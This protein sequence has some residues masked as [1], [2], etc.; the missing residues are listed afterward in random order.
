MASAESIFDSVYRQ[1]LLE[2]VDDGVFQRA[3]STLGAADDDLIDLKLG[4][5]LD[6]ELWIAAI[7]VG[8]AVGASSGSPNAA[9]ATAYKVFDQWL[10][11]IVAASTKRRIELRD[12][13]LASTAALWSR[14]P[15]ELRH[16]LRLGS[17]ATVVEASTDTEKSWPLKVQDAVSRALIMIARQSGREDIFRARELVEE[18]RRLQSGMEAG[19]LGATNQPQRSALTL[20]AL[21]HAGQATIVLTDYVLSG[22][23]IGAKGRAVNVITELQTLVRKAHEYAVLSSDPELMTWI[24]SVALIAGKLRSDSIWATGANINE[25]TDALVRAV[26]S[27]EGAILSM[28]PSQQDALAKNLLDPQREAIVLQ[29]PT[30]SGK[31][32]MAEMAILQTLS[33]YGDSR[34]V[35]LTPT[36]ALATQIRRTLGFDFS[37]LNIDVTSAGS[38]FEEDPFEQALL[39]QLSGVI[40]STP[41][42]L[43]LLLR[44]RS[45]W[46]DNVRLVIVDEAHLLKDG[47]RGA[48]LELLLSNIRREHAHIRLLLLTP[49]VENAQDV[50]NWL[51]ED[52]GGEVGVQWRPSRLIIG[53]ATVKGR[54]GTRRIE[55]EWKEPHRHSALTNTVIQLS[56]EERDRLRDSPSAMTKA[57]TIGR[58]L[59]PLGPALMMFPD[60]RIR[61]EQT[62]LEMSADRENIDPAGEGPEFRVAV[63]LATNEYGDNSE[64][65]RCLKKGVAFHHSALSSEL[66]YLVERLA[67]QGTLK[68]IAATTTLAQGMNF[69]VSSV[70]VHSVSKPWSGSLTPGEFW[71][72]AG[73]AGRVGLSERGLVVFANSD[74][75]EHWQR[76]T[77]YLSERVESALADAVARVAEGADIKSTYRTNEGIRPFIQ[78]LGHSVARMGARET[79][80]DLE[81]LVT[82]SFAAKSP[83]ARASLLRLARRYVGEVA[84]KQ[85]SYMKVA[86]ETGL[87][88]FSFDELY[89]TIRNDPVLAHGTAHDLQQPAGL[90]HLIDALAKLPELSLALDKGH[91]TI[92]TE[93]VAGIVHQWINGASIQDIAPSFPGDAASDRIRNAGRYV[94]GLVSQTVSWGAHAFMR[95]RDMVNGRG[96]ELAGVDRML[97][98]YIQYGVN[99]PASVMA[100]ILGVPRQLATPIANLYHEANGP[101]RT[102]DGAKFREFLVASSVEVWRDAVSGTAMAGAVSAEDLRSVWRDAQG[103]GL[104]RPARVAQE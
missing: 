74:H 89:A 26:S 103:I 64:L 3:F 45:E 36:R 70:V 91:G 23:F 79:A 1:R 40:V 77:T 44:S 31:T 93:A 11:Y 38:A 9:D 99:S 13:F 57:I 54:M 87:A 51:S 75:R 5:M 66:R 100:S 62:A 76:Y 42:K 58:R 80:S 60:S 35:Y 19:L 8:N 86:D 72:I 28:L 12:L 53:L 50:A 65:A 41:E 24:T 30:S 104:K 98:A 56:L 85:Q 59:S 101:L 21:Y 15:T 29:M 17:V 32:L 46:F 88:S 25:K 94:F 55:I 67:A 6:Y 34:V 97:P 4:A 68:F 71:N 48:R 14:R 47:E 90:K 49:F 37:D 81:R 84:S 22:Q 52:R 95:G 16:V 73:R 18:L 69:P 39:D 43:D 27:R 83:S 61:A 7:D 78:Y 20:L 63:A 33:S 82:A 102:D 96:A 92:D 2:R 10:A